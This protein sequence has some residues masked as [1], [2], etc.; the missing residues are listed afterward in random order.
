[1]EFLFRTMIN[2]TK[3]EVQYK[4]QQTS[5]ITSQRQAVVGLSILD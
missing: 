4:T 3:Y 5:S 1:M 2:T